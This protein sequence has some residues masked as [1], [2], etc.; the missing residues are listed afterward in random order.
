MGAGSP[1]IPCVDCA[2]L[3]QPRQGTHWQASLPGICGRK[4]HSLFQKHWMSWKLAFLSTYSNRC[5]KGYIASCALQSNLRLRRN[6]L[7]LQMPIKNANG[8]IP[9]QLHI[10]VILDNMKV[11][12]ATC[13][14]LK[15][16]NTNQTFTP[17]FCSGIQRATYLRCNNY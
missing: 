7:A 14:Q 8:Y 12:G 10:D 13:P 1:E 5:S 15:Q 4:N 11:L 17:R 6:T 2:F 3:F 9:K 16:V